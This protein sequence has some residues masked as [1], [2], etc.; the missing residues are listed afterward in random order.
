MIHRFGDIR[1]DRSKSY[2]F[3]FGHE[4]RGVDQQV[5]DECDI[6][7]DIPQYGTKHSL[8]ISVTA[9]LVIWEAFRQF[10][11]EQLTELLERI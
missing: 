9:G 5:V 3:V 1:I 7:L 4:V 11:M 6:S 8:N 10:R 2:A